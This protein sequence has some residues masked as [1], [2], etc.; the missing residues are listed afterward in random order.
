MHGNPQPTHL[1]R[2]NWR[3]AWRPLPIGIAL[4]V[5]IVLSMLAV[6]IT[7]ADGGREILVQ[8]KCD[9]V[10]FNAELGSG[11]CV[12]K[13]DVTFDEFLEKLNPHDGGHGAWR[14]SRDAL[15][16]R[17][18]EVVRVTNT[19][20]EGHTFTE[21]FMFGG[22]FIPPLNAALP[23][24]TPLATPVS[25]LPLEAAANETFLPSGLSINLSNLSKGRHKFQCLIHPWMRTVIEVRNS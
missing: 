13:G 25:G 5:M 20:G 21:V 22:G 15:T 16:I 10:T 19:G 4:A 12:G 18:G 3:G 17:R 6:P 7:F 9:P 24:G 1:P 23:D 11:A 2:L 8:D 14:F